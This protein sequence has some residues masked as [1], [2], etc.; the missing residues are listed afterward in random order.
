M[1]SVYGIGNP[2]MDM[3]VHVDFPLLDSLKKIPGSMNLVDYNELLSILEVIGNNVNIVKVP[4]GSCA[5]TIRGI[6]WFERN[7]FKE[8]DVPVYSG[9]VGRD[10]NGVYYSDIMSKFGVHAVLAKKE[11]V[12]GT[13]LILVTPDH[14]RTMF[15]YLGACRD[16]SYSDTDY[17]MLGSS[18]Y[19]YFVGFMWDTNSQKD[20]I[21]KAVSYA[22][23]NDI[24]VCFDLAGPF[25]V[26]R[27]R[28]EFLEWIP[29]NVDILLGNREEFAKLVSVGDVSDEGIVQVVLDMAP[30]AVMKCG[31]DGCL[32]GEKLDNSVITKIQGN[33]VNAIDTTGAGDSFAAGFLFGL[34]NGK[35]YYESASIGNLLAS[36]I[37]TVEGCDY[38]S[39][40]FSM[41]LRG[42]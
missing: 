18:D 17:S 22:R 34:L 13:S 5:N 37:V 9:A 33:S 3:I 21:K 36:Q 26:D 1:P 7:G 40:D 15:T 10:E 4:G 24:R 31:K 20:A 6:A 11:S 29:A 8:I 41:V 23:E 38:D 42:I 19:L 39:L 32:V 30:V 27:Y 25:V 2:L 16:Y 14:E 12:T 35:N 28:E